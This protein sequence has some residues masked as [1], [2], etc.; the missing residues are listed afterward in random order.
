MD[1]KMLKSV[2]LVYKICTCIATRWLTVSIPCSVCS[3]LSQSP[4]VLCSMPVNVNE[5]VKLNNH[6][7]GTI[8]QNM[9]TSKAS[10][11]DTNMPLLTPSAPHLPEANA[12]WHWKK[13]SNNCIHRH[14]SGTV[15]S[16]L[17]DTLLPWHHLNLPSKPTSSSDTTSNYSSSKA[18]SSNVLCSDFNIQHLVSPF[19][20]RHAL[21]PDPRYLEPGHAALPAWLAPV[22][23]PLRRLSCYG[24]WHPWVAETRYG[25]RHVS[26]APPWCLVGGL[27]AWTR[28]RWCS[29][30]AVQA[31]SG[32]LVMGK[33]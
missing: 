11:F 25:R 31:L 24:E 12:Y 8:V 13:K 7:T 6:T 3:P 20:R 21:S 17:S 29:R 15:C 27:W 9:L 22:S 30:E 28:H 33:V 18:H 14:Y 2:Q 32:H 4:C 23:A 1:R 10:C 5:T 19:E 26:A 16:T